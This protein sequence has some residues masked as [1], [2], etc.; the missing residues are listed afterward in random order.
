MKFN[1]LFT[2]AL[3]AALCPPGAVADDGVEAKAAAC[4]ACHGPQGNSTDGTYPILAGQ[5]A[6]YIYVE[7]RDFKEGRRKNPLMSPMAAALSKQD[8]LE[9]ADYFS[10]Q[11]ARSP[12]F[13]PDAEKVALGQ[14]KAEETLCSMC[15]LG[16][17]AGQ[18]EIPRVAGQQPQYVIKQLMDFKNH[19]R[20]NDAGN[21]SSVAKT[22]SDQD[23]ENLA[24]Y[25][26]S[27]Y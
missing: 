25:I 1:H 19:Q 14:K 16:G 8:M 2:V 7:L 3:L 21:M 17:F 23:M 26:A 11:K 4:M 6:R 27:L 13:K 22:L 5:N 20:T 24:N 10:A 9:L 15:H 18:N 12:D